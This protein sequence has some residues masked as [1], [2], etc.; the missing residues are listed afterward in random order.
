MKIIRRPT[1]AHPGPLLLVYFSLAIKLPIFQDIKFEFR[2]NQTSCNHSLELQ[3]ISNKNP[4]NLPKKKNHSLL[5]SYV[6]AK[7][8]GRREKTACIR[9]A[10]SRPGIDTDAL[11]QGG[12]HPTPGQKKR[13]SSFLKERKEK[14]QGISLHCRVK[15]PL[16]RLNPGGLL[17][18]PL[19][20]LTS[21]PC[22]EDKAFSAC[23]GK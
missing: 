1:S 14:G 13:E 7:K 19:L 21:L 20:L 2:E 9:E 3:C 22:G 10:F 8:G 4:Q 23:C 15:T 18:N 16:F 5:K 6:F 11:K 17:P 12:P